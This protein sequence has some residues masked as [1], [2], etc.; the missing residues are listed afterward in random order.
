MP[1]GPDVRLPGP[2]R[3]DSGRATAPVFAGI[4]LVAMGT[5]AFQVLLTRIFSVTMWYHFAF[6]A[7]SLAM[8]GL[9][10]GAVYV[11]LRPGPFTG[12]RIPGSLT[13]CA[14][15]F[16]ASIVASIWVH[17]SVPFFSEASARGFCSVLLHFCVIAVPFFFSGIV[18]CAILTRFPR[19]MGGLYA[20]DL[21]GAAAGCVAVILLL[22]WLDGPLAVLAIAAAVAIAAFL[23]A[24]GGGEELTWVEA[25]GGR[26]GC[27]L[28]RAGRWA[29]G[30]GAARGAIAPGL[31]QGEP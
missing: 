29:P 16:S 10:T 9:T 11:Y 21:V 13:R 30:V 4:F 2:E 6:M 26:H 19:Q 5:V 7:I 22:R 17:A 8:F 28:R 14:A 12:P 25:R 24:Q 31:G 23:F 27:G 3:G 18:I 1:H 15:L 20:A